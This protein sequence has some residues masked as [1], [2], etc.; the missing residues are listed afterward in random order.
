MALVPVFVT[1]DDLPWIP[2]SDF[3]G[4]VSL[5]DGRETVY[6]KTLSDRREHGEGVARIIRFCPPPGLLITVL[7]IARSDEHIL[8]LTGGH[9]DKTGRPRQAPGDYMLHPRGHRHGAMLAQETTA[10]VVYTGEPDELLD[11]RIAPLRGQGSDAGADRM[12]E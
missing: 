10:F 9:C 12:S 2:G 4:E 5:S 7:A 8:I 3:L 11:F 1:A 6:M